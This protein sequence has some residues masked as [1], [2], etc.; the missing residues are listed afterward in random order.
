MAMARTSNHAQ[1]Q[2]R[3]SGGRWAQETI[4]PCGF[5]SG[6]AGNSLSVANRARGQYCD[7]RWAGKLAVVTN[8]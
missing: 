7:Q 2:V 3:D 4:D 6:R 8:K 1:L 5:K